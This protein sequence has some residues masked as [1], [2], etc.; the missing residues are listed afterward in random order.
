MILDYHTSLKIKTLVVHDCPLWSNVDMARSLSQDGIQTVMKDFIQSGHG[1]WQ[2]DEL[3]YEQEVEKED[4]PAEP[5]KESIDYGML[6][7]EYN[8]RWS[9]A[10]YKT[11]AT[12]TDNVT[13]S[14]TLTPYEPKLDKGEVLTTKECMGMEDLDL[15]A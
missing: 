13:D 2:D 6:E 7:G 11:T 4:T 12:T 3:V 8:Q 15:E 10:D 5:I 9:K 1:E 14:M